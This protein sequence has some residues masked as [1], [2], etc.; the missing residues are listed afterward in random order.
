MEIK[1]P[2]TTTPVAPR[3]AEALQPKGTL[4]Q[5]TS[6]ERVEKLTDMEKHVQGFADIPMSKGK[7][8]VIVTAAST[9]QVLEA[10]GLK[11]E[12]TGIFD[13]AGAKL[14]KHGGELLTNLFSKRQGHPD[15][16]ETKKLAEVGVRGVRDGIQ[17]D[18]GMFDKATGM[19]DAHK[20]A[21]WWVKTGDGKDYLTAGDIK[22][23]LNGPGV[24][25]LGIFGL[26][27]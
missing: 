12:S 16:L 8:D 22:R 27:K 3:T 20:A 13:I 18:T 1:K 25:F 9:Q 4:A 2:P 7:N 19:I 17:G 15:F 26:H 24:E 10:M 21:E 6:T 11:V 14:D 23:Y 5:A